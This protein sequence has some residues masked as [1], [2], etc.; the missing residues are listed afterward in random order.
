[1]IGRIVTAL[2][3]LA[4]LVSTAGSCGQIAQTQQFG[5]PT[6]PTYP[7]DHYE[8]GHCFTDGMQTAPAN[9]ERLCER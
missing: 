4:I 1:M 2:I 8:P 9:A 3:V 7:A 5:G 6:P